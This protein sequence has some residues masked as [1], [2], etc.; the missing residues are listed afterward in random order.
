MKNSIIEINK[1]KSKAGRLPIKLILHEIY[2]DTNSYNL[3]GISWNRQYT[4]DNIESVKSIPLVTQFID[5][6]NAI[7]L[8]GHGEM[9]AVDGDVYFE[10]SVVVGAF[11]NAYIDDNIEIN[12]K[13][14]SALVG[15][16]YIFNQRFP[17]FTEYLQEQYE[18]GIPIEGSI[19]IN[20]DKSNGNT[21]II[22]DGGYKEK[23][24]IPQ[25]YQYSGHAL[26]FGETPAD[27]SSILLELNSYKN[28][29]GD[30]QKMK[31]DIIN[32][33][34]TIEINKL[35]FDDM[36]CLITRAFN[37]AMG[38][39]DYYNDYYIHRFY[40]ESNEVVFTKW[41]DPGN[42][43]M[44][45]YKVE[46]NSVTI[47]DIIQVSEEWVPVSNSQSVEV[48]I[49]KI[50]EIITNKGG[51]E[52]MNVEELNVKIA[53][54][55]AQ[56]TELNNKVTE[57]NSANVEK[58]AKIA[59]LNETIINANKSLEEVNTKCSALEV[60]CNGYKEEKEKMET[61]KKQA[62]INTYFET[63]IPKNNFEEAEVNSLKEYVE[64]C[65]L[66]G[67]K[68]AEADLIVKRFKEG[69]LNTVE[70]NSKKE[71]N[72]FF[73]TKEEKVDDIEAGKSLFV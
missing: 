51:N 8:G 23:G 31:K 24:R 59:E 35:S 10:D 67:L 70:T 54:L 7:P 12:G 9:N 57:L 48:N 17:K 11:E 6:N 2:A 50:R 65:D 39:T 16:A 53:E 45:T 25:L 38:V 69:K 63:E 46:N 13:T 20:A 47:G 32:K 26:L 28:K 68:K 66:E 19:E 3:N 34:V 49:N 71:E 5:E 27:P 36:A 21:K 40:P 55:N 30:S 52:G 42:Y 22:Y 33:G 18:N 43:Y 4:E 73:H 37:K 1:K 14:I 72:I 64:K 15:E 58:D 61:E 62:E 44:T 60:E 41:Q 56:L 29:E